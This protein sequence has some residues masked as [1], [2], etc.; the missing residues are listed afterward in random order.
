MNAELTA[1]ITHYGYLAIFSLVF[2]QEIGVPNPV[3]NELVL[4]FSGYLASIGTLSLPLLFLIVVFADFLGTSL[5]YG[6]FYV[7]GKT[8]LKNKPRWIPIHKEHIERLGKFISK[9][10]WWGIYLGRLIPY[11]RGYASVAAGLLQLRPRVFLIMVFLSALTWSGGYV[12]AGKIMGPY[13]QVVADKIGGTSRLVYVILGG[14]LLFYFAR[15]LLKWRR[16]YK[17]KEVL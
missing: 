11:V 4:L 10:D 13:W 14:L 16:A 7:F 15:Q 3:P 2:L 5:L 1:Y 9:R 12:V 8:I 17:N 6:V